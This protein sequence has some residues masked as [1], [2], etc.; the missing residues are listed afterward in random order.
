MIP[1]FERLVE[2]FEIQPGVLIPPGSYRWTQWQ[3]EVSTASKRPWVAEVEASRGGFYTGTMTQFSTELTLKPSRHLV[4][5]A[6]LEINDVSLPEGEFVARVFSTRVDF[7][8]SPN[9]AWSNQ[10]QYDT[11]SRILGFQ[12]RLR[13]ILKPGNDIFLVFGRGWFHRPD[14]RY[15]R[16][17]D[18]G[19]AKLQ[20]TFR[21]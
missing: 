8:A 20:Y 5:A 16:E 9:V 7:S 14:G 6:Q 4:V 13:W 11:D 12:S 18:S 3:V 17:F 1:T 19:S 10:V 2:P 15:T 21:L